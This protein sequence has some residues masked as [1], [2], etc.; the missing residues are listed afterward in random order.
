MTKTFRDLFYSGVIFSCCILLSCSKKTKKEPFVSDYNKYSLFFS[1]NNFA[2]FNAETSAVLLLNDHGCLPCIKMYSNFVS[3]YINFKNVIIVLDSEGTYFDISPFIND[4]IKNIFWDTH[5][6]FKNVSGI[7]Y[8][9]AILW[10]NQKID[11]TI[12]INFENLEGK[13][14]YIEERLLKK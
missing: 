3:G 14:S 1:N 6:E 8:S 7:N 9:A 2:A 4:T 12:E 13:L 5:Q 10:K 11:T